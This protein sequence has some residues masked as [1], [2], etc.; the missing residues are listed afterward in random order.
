MTL[1][2]NAYSAGWGEGVVLTVRELA[3]TSKK[4]GSVT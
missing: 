1:V 3:K 2:I 4:H